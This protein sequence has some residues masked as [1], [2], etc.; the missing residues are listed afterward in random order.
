MKVSKKL[1]LLETET[2]FEVL[3]KANKLKKEG[4]NIINLGIGQPDFPTPKNIVDAAI[5]A[6]RDGHHGY[7]PSNGIIELREAVSKHIYKNYN[8]NVNPD[9]I[10][11]TPGGKPVIF[12]AALIFGNNDSEIIYPDPGFPIYRS[13]IKFSGAKPVPLTL[14]EKNNFEIDVDELYALINDKTRLI[15]INNPNNP[16]GSFMYES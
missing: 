8:V 12:F 9:K 2:A 1:S 4:K 3:A 7:T 16:T 5:K 14:K 11:I 10:L 13:M 6:L 15:I